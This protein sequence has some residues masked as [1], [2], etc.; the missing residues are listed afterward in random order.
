MAALCS[1][2]LA[3]VGIS[4]LRRLKTPICWLA[5]LQ[6]EPMC[7]LDNLIDFSCSMLTP[8]ICRFMLFA[9]D[10]APSTMVWYFW[11][12]T[13][14]KFSLYH[15]V[16]LLPSLSSLPST[17]LV[18]EPEAKLWWLSACIEISFSVISARSFWTE[19]HKRAP[20]E[21]PWG[22]PLTVFFHWLIT[23]PSLTLF[24]LWEKYKCRR[25]RADPERLYDSSSW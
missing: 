18:D 15:L 3:W 21:D 7:S 10:S 22:Q 5:F 9:S 13:C 23:E 12:F 11:T 2:T 19:F 1:C 17:I 20:N 25:L 16:I 24:C 4:I 8:S 6:T 14:S